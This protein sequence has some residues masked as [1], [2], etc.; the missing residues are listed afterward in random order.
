VSAQVAPA[1]WHGRLELGFER[2]GPR[3]LLARSAARMP[4]ALQR[5]F[6]PEGE[7]VCHTV[8]LH[9]PGGMV[10]G[11]R[12]EMEMA[13]AADAEVLV[14][15]PSATRWYRSL[16]QAEQRVTARVADC[17]HLEWL[18][19]ETIVFDGARARQT[20]TVELAPGASFLGWE[21]TRFGRSHSGESFMRGSWRAATE[22]WRD[23]KPLWIDRQRLAG[24]AALMHSAHGLAGQPVVGTLAYVGRALESDFVEQVRALW[25]ADGAEAATAPSLARGPRLD[26]GMESRAM[27]Q[28]CCGYGFDPIGEGEAGVTRLGEGLL[29]R[30]RGRSSAA[31]H[32]WFAAVWDLIRRHTR[33]RTAQRPRIWST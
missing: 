31:A 16:S 30:Y 8:L 19:L 11:D 1:A 13:L 18:P 9:P 25:A 3:T 12:L 7:A 14:T 10:G 26:S 5:P 17:A 29:C 6:Y 28:G 24:G 33:G 32:A 4:L 22:V 23:G 21:V 15:T 20:V 2:R 27:Q